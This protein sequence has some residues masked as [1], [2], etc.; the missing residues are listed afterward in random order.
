[1]EGW[2]HPCMRQQ[3]NSAPRLVSLLAL[4]AWRQSEVTRFSPWA[5]HLLAVGGDVAE[6]SARCLNVPICEMEP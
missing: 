3:Q 6:A 5:C 2:G 4:T 1:M